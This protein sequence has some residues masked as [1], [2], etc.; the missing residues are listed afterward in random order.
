MGRAAKALIALVV[1]GLL[2]LSGCAG[3]NPNHAA[4]I[5]GVAIPVSEVEA[6]LPVLTPY[7]QNPSV[8]TV[9]SVLVTTRIG[10]EVARQQQL[11]FTAE[12]REAAAASVMPPELAADPQAASFATDYVT[13]ALVSEKLGQDAFLA[14]VAKL[15]VVVNPRYGTWDA[16]H[17]AV[18]PGTGSLSDPAPAS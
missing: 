11:E 3:Q 1:A 17:A 6:M 4:S 9:T 14:A 15:D 8:A 13:T 16:S 5:D 2:T 18:V 10:A 12:Q 7:L